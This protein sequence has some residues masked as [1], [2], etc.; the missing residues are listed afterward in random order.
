MQ[1]I[2]EQEADKCQHNLLTTSE[3]AAFISDE[4]ENGSCRDIMFTQCSNGDVSFSLE[5]ISHTYNAYTS[6]H[7]VLMF[8]H[9]DAE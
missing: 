3:V 6:L 9:D 8:P 5:V 4:H 7:Y 2:L 1:L